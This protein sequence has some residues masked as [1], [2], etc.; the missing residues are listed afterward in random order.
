MLVGCGVNMAQHWH[1]AGQTSAAAQRS[2]VFRNIWTSRAYI[3]QRRS[4]RRAP[5]LHFRSRGAVEQWSQ[6]GVHGPH[7]QPLPVSR[8]A[9]GPIGA[10][11]DAADGI[12]PLPVVDLQ[13][14]GHVGL[15][16]DCLQP[17]QC[18]GSSWGRRAHTGWLAG[19]FMPCAATLCITSTANGLPSGCPARTC[20]WRSKFCRI[21]GSRARALTVASTC[22]CPRVTMHAPS[23]ARASSPASNAMSE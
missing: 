23:A 6:C 21:H 17:W 3:R 12:Q 7:D 10:G 20:S 16:D 5:H 4:T 15:P 11:W 13:R 9:L 2:F 19:R 14:S 8:C 18:F 1:V 22:V